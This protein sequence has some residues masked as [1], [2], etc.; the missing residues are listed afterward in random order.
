MYMQLFQLKTDYAAN[1]VSCLALSEFKGGCTNNLLSRS[2]L[3]E[4]PSHV[5]QLLT[6]F[7]DEATRSV[8]FVLLHDKIY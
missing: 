4:R 7:G 8:S 3:F 1:K 2:H 5:G 6:A